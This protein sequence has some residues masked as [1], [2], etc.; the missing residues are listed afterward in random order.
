MRK[1]DEGD[2][3][4]LRN[5][6]ETRMMSGSFALPDAPEWREF[7]DLTKAHEELLKKFSRVK[8]KKDMLGRQLNQVNN[9][10]REVKKANKTLTTRHATPT[11]I[12]IL[13]EPQESESITEYIEKNGGMPG[14]RGGPTF[15][16]PAAVPAPAPDM[17][18]TY[19]LG[20]MLTPPEN[21]T[22]KTTIR[23]D[24]CCQ[25][26]LVNPAPS[27]EQE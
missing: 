16:I 25:K 14:Y 13:E 8:A 11:P 6:T 26:E 17:S 19:A 24:S 18:Q 7:N 10:L 1:F 4:R 27:Q 2:L 12:P 9:K 20:A 15:Q 3:K 22:E 23:R 21:A 5:F